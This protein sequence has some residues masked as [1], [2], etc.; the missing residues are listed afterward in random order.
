MIAGGIFV[1]LY[2]RKFKFNMLKIIDIIV[3]GLIIGQAIGRWGNFF[4]QEAYG[5][6]VSLDFLQSLP[7][8]DFIV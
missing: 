8:P 2:A 3:V 1:L 4:N 6:I 5:G 7:I